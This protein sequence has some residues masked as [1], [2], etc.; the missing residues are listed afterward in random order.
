MK[1]LIYSSASF[2]DNTLPLYKAMKDKGVDVTLLYELHGANVNLFNEKEMIPRAGILKATEYQSFKRYEKY[3]DL[4]DVYVENNPN[5]SI[6]DIKNLKSTY[7]VARFIKEGNFD[8]I[9]TD[10]VI[11]LWKAPL[12]LFRKKI[13]L[14][15]HEAIPHA[16]KL[17][18]LIAMFRKVN[19]RM[20]PK[21]VVLNHAVYEQFCEKY[22]ISKNRVLV[23]KLGPL[24]CIRIFA[25]DECSYNPNKIVFWGRI[26]RY[27]G[28]EYLCQAMTIVHNQ[29]PQAKLVIAGGGDFYFDINPYR[30]L[31]YI[32]IENRYFDMDELAEIIEDAALTVCP[33]VSSSQS[34]GVITSLVMGKPV[35]GTN[36]ET[37]REMIDDGVTG[38]LVPPRDINALA[39]A[40]IRLLTNPQLQKQMMENIRNNNAKDNTWS[41]I[42]DKY[43]DFYKIEI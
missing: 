41:Q 36:Y 24:D 39:D 9:H 19:Y 29:I 1:V 18:P 11:M 34:G 14:I 21:L 16:K 2:S 4:K 10:M 17:H 6:Q 35:I 7:R 25:K 26:A 12:L 42:A 8:I 38:L 23:N 37:M 20:V 3:C 13:V 43:L 15:M 32:K 30:L 40:M 27:K 28:L 22:G 31:S 33:Y 5:S